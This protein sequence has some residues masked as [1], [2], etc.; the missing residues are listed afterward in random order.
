LVDRRTGLTAKHQAAGIARWIGAHLT[1]IW[2]ALK[3]N[4]SAVQKARSL[5]KIFKIQ[6][7]LRNR[8]KL[9][10]LKIQKSG[11]LSLCTRAG[12]GVGLQAFGKWWSTKTPA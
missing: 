3:A 5:Q 10:F 6:K 2:P 11:R 4:G 7:T 1:Y 12:A 9:H 8:R